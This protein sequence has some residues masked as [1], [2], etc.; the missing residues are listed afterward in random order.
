MVI[1]FLSVE[2][3]TSN[4]LQEAENFAL[5][6]LIKVFVS[7]QVLISNGRMLTHRSITREILGI[8]LETPNVI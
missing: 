5:R 4:V 6:Q 7:H 3:N 1:L 8:L 2:G